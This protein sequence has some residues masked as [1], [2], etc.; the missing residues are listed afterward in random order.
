MYHWHKNRHIDQW[1]RIESPEINLKAMVNYSTMKEARIYNGENTVSSIVLL[2]KLSS[3]MYKN[4]I[5]TFS[6]ITYKQIQN[7]LKT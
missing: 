2:G 1:N 3:L 4:A 5:R 7:G 6:H